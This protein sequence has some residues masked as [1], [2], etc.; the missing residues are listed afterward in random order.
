M[1]KNSSESSGMSL[2]GFLGLIFVV[3]KLTRLISWSWWWVTI[4]FW[5]GI[6]IF[7][8]GVLILLIIHLA[9]K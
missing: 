5:G 2:L 1:S 9:E 4:P 7:L 3:L 8:V 6:A